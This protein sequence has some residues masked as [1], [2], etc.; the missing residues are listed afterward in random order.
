MY[1]ST[2]HDHKQA[3]N[4]NPPMKSPTYP[5]CLIGGIGCILGLLGGNAH[6]VL[7]LLELDLQ[8]VQSVQKVGQAVVRVRG[9]ALACLSLR[10]DLHKKV[11]DAECIR[12]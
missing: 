3:Q 7:H 9:D 8:G 11:R 10:L 12:F 4:L 2:Q 6:F 5:L 1:I